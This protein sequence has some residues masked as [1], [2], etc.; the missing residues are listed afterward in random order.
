MI[1]K[2]YWAQKKD[3][4]GTDSVYMTIY[5]NYILLISL[6]ISI[7]NV[8]LGDLFQQKFDSRCMGTFAML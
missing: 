2:E 3:R 5:I 7:L 1:C 6:D 8:C 4:F